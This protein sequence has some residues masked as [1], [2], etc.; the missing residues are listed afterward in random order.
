MSDLGEVVKEHPMVLAAGVVLV[1][2]LAYHASRA[3]SGGTVMVTS[4]GTPTT[5]P[6]AAAVQE[7]TIQAG[8]QN[9][10]TLASLIANTTQTG[11]QRDVALATTEAQQ[12]ATDRATNAAVTLGLA[13]TDAQR[14]VA[15]FT[16]QAQ[17]DA[18]A[19]ETRLGLASI[20]ANQTTALAQTAANKAVARANDNTSIVNGIVRTIGGIAAFI[21]G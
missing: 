1:A 17:A 2:A 12:E 19:A 7:A 10:Q 5:D 18:T 21:F 16:A 15:A 3:S 6:N 11:A 13:Q 8:A 4:N 9:V 14:A 20:N